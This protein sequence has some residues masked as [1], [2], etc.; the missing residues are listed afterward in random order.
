MF[1]RRNLF[2]VAASVTAAV[3]QPESPGSEDDR[4]GQA[5]GIRVAAAGLER[6]AF[7]PGH[8][9]NGD[10]ERFASRIG[11]FSKGLPHNDLGEVDPAAYNIFRNALV[12]GADQNE[13]ERVPMGASSASV[14]RKLV[15]PCA[16][17]CF[18]LQGADSHHLV[19]PPAPGLM[20]AETAGE[21]VELYWQALLRDVPFAVYDSHPLAQ[22]AAADLSKLSD[23]R[24]PKARGM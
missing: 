23:F 8:P 11:N 24:G 6:D 17:A 14:Q 4:L 21:M 1:T 3:A 19:M 2:G 16:G 15:D 13:L 7:L 18:D 12:R 10:E 20:S 9:D 5:Y 22:A